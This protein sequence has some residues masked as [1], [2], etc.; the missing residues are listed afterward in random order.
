MPVVQPSIF[1]IIKKFPQQRENIIGLHNNSH[2]FRAMCSDLNTCRDAL[3]YWSQQESS[4][5]NSREREYREL[6][7]NL[8]SEIDRYLKANRTNQ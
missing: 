8:W 5:A 1:E 3:K 4:E 2:T 6:L 7:E